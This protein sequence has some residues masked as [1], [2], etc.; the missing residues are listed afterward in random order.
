[1]DTGGLAPVSFILRLWFPCISEH[2]LGLK[3]EPSFLM[4][5]VAWPRKVSVTCLKSRSVAPRKYGIIAN[6]RLRSPPN[7]WLHS[8]HQLVHGDLVD[9]GASMIIF[10]IKRLLNSSALLPSELDIYRKSNH[11]HWT[12]NSYIEREQMYKL[13]LLRCKWRKRLVKLFSCGRTRLPNL[14]FYSR[15]SSF[16]VFGL[17]DSHV[18]IV[19]INTPSAED[20]W[21]QR[22]TSTSDVIWRC[23]WGRTSCMPRTSN[24]GVQS[25][26]CFLF[27]ELPRGST[28]WTNEWDC[29]R[30]KP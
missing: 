17:I 16:F 2:L 20:W 8:E 12:Y 18:G 9:C 14:T 29:R 13:I 6:P 30:K 11:A 1:M 10:R 7:K 5:S 3:V 4:Y 28:H 23:I 22:F 21:S 27:F 26:T 15:S 24:E 19:V 25:V